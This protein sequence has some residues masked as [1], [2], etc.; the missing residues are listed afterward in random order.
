MIEPGD[1]NETPPGHMC[2]WIATD[3]DHCVYCGEPAKDCEVESHNHPQAPEQNHASH[4][5][6]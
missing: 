1:E 5:T 6:R 2:L 4:E 3:L